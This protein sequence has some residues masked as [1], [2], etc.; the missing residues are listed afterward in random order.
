MSSWEPEAHHLS[1]TRTARYYTLGRP[2]PSVQTCWFVL[3]GYGQLAAS[4]LDTFRPLADA[5]RLFVA[6]EGLSR[7]Y[8]EGFS[9]PVGA[10]WMTREDRAAEIADYVAYLDALH[11]RL[12]EQLPDAALHVLGF[13]QGAATACRWLALGRARA[14]RLILWTGDVP[15]DLPAEA[16]RRLP[17]PELVFGTRDRL[18]DATRRQQLVTRLERLDLQP[19]VRL[20]DG[21]HRLHEPLLR[22]LLSARPS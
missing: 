1:V 21:G 16:A 19:A 10:S 22:E 14:R 15:E 13:S 20:F 2:G 17:T 4:F 11:A 12:Q 8:L 9:G 3:H 7:F 5:S 18:I 6:P